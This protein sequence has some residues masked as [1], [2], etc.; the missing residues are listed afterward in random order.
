[1]RL[2]LFAL[3]FL[4]FVF[5]IPQHI[6]AQE[7]IIKRSTIV[8]NFKGKPYYMHFVKWG[9]TLS[10]IAKV[11]NVTIQD[12]SAENPSVE[13]GL[14]ADMVLRIPQKSVSKS[15]VEVPNPVSINQQ[16][17]PDEKPKVQIKPVEKQTEPAKHVEE[18]TEQAKPV[19]KSTVQSI[20]AVDRDFVIY[21]VKKRETLYG[22][23]K[24][25]NV[26]VDDII[27]ANTGL[28]KLDE[29][30]EIKIPQKKP[31]DAK[32]AANEAAAEKILKQYS[33]PNEILI[34]PGETLSGIS[35]TYNISIHDL[36]ELNPKLTD[37]LKAGMTLKLR[38]TD[39]KTAVKPAL[40]SDEVS[41]IVPVPALICYSADNIK[42]TYNV[43]LLLP[44]LLDDSQDALEA[45]EQKKASDFDNFNYF[46]FYAGFMLAADSLRQYGLRA[47]IQVLDGDKLNDTLTIRQTLRKPG[48]DKMD[49][50]VGPMYANSFAVAARYALKHE[51]GILNPLSRRENI[52]DGNPFVLKAQVTSAGIATKLSTFILRQYTNAN[53][54]SVRND[55]KELKS[56]ADE[57]DSQ[58]RSSIS[59][60]TFK[61]SLQG[62]TYSTD[63]MAGVSKKL[64]P[65]TKNIII[66]FSNNKSNVPNFVS[67][68]N[69]LSK[70]DDII[71]IGMDSWDELE[72]ETEFLVN[73]KYH[74][75]TTS[76]IDYESEAVQQFITRFRNKYGAV[77][78]A[79]KHAF[80]GYDLGW[81]FL[82]SLMWYGDHYITCLPEQKGK[83]LQYNFNF[84]GAGKG[85]G[86]QNQDIS[87]VKLQDYKIVKVE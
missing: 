53:I 58:I 66:F 68:L 44:F 45:P 26:S 49:L 61:G 64:K 19:E 21:L 30:M 85:D 15:V 77:P 33:N 20:P 4:I 86:L 6:I 83:C 71:L 84:S 57:F 48:M 28:Q 29:G 36:T 23:A 60:R 81:Y 9:E 38:K 50:I 73:L 31:V 43:A 80:L 51:I 10:Q 87:I 65:N 3:Q 52:V 8:E 63:M 56:L 72:L 11:Y 25:F 69:P 37:G 42:A 62:A 12:I 34:K 16:P 59:G 17:K 24:E 1:M 22:I 55:A 46:Q 74:Q 32:P 5:T 47:R 79:S 41:V 54:I 67:L 70:S 2:R 35:K 76:Y 75:L 39:V 13:K 27:N 7:V 14:K 82:T 18:Q 40:K 78:L